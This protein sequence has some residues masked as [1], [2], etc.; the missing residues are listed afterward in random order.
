MIDVF[1]DAANDPGSLDKLAVFLAF[2]QMIEGA[3]LSSGQRS[4]SFFAEYGILNHRREIARGGNAGH[5]DKIADDRLAGAALF[6][7]INV[8]INSARFVREKSKPA[9]AP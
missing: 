1:G 3:G 9:R 7:Q 6:R 8:Q 2:H 5:F 4:F